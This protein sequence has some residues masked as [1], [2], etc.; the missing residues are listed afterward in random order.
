MRPVSGASGAFGEDHEAVAHPHAWVVPHEIHV[1]RHVAWRRCGFFS[2]H[3]KARSPGRCSARPATIV[4]GAGRAGGIR[5]LARR[6]TT[7]ARTSTGRFPGENKERRRSPG[8]P[9]PGAHP[10]ASNARSPETWVSGRGRIA[11]VIVE[12]PWNWVGMVVSWGRASV[13]RPDAGRCSGR[14]GGVPPSTC[15]KS[16]STDACPPDAIDHDIYAIAPF[17][18]MPRRPLTIEGCGFSE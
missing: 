18:S 10:T 15:P 4:S 2:K 6:V 16:T 1:T 13:G 12:T 5:A 14:P 3:V 7:P 17:D 8:V 9:T 11:S